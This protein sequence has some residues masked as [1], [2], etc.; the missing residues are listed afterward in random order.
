MKYDDVEHL[1]VR[2]VGYY[3]RSVVY[4]LQAQWALP[5]QEPRKFYL[6]EIPC[7]NRPITGALG[8]LC[9]RSN[10]NDVMRHMTL[11]YIRTAQSSVMGS[12][13]KILPDH[14]VFKRTSNFQ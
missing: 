1:V 5:L 4:S 10:I 3:P 8:V 2:Y 12:A 14:V 7:K 11:S 9:I 6:I 13:Q